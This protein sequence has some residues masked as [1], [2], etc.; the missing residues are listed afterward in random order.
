MV[1]RAHGFES[2]RGRGGA[3]EAACHRRAD[4]FAERGL[5][6][7]AYCGPLARRAAFTT[8]ETLAKTAIAVDPAL[9][10]LGHLANVENF[11]TPVG[12][13]RA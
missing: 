9:R 12:A 7:I 11:A 5:T 13:A 1:H 3:F 4:C 8:V 2:R 6:E 10:K